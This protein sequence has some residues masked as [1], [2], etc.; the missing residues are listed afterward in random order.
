M[1]AGATA[2]HRARRERVLLR[3]IFRFGTAT[4]ALLSVV[5]VIPADP[6]RSVCGVQQ[7]QR[8]PSWVGAVAMAMLRAEFREPATALRAQAR[9]VARA[10]RRKRQREHHRVAAG[11]LEVEVVTVEVVLLFCCL[12]VPSDLGNQVTEEF[13]E[14]NLDGRGNGIQTAR[15]LARKRRAHRAGSQHALHHCLEPYVQF[16]AGTRRDGDHLNPE[17]GRRPHCAVLSTRGSRLA[18]ERTHVENERAAGIA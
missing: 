8:R 12:A 10:K 11:W 5:C 17:A 1:S 16:E 3:D 6:G 4:S 7:P 9:A 2:F 18:P 14:T 15:A 13:L